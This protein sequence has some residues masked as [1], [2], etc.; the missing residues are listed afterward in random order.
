M[1]G[2]QRQ[3]VQEVRHYD[4]RFRENKKREETMVP[5]AMPKSVITFA[6]LKIQ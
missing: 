1:R 5:I 6:M 3:A 2:G 4:L